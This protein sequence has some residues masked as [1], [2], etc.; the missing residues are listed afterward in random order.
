MNVVAQGVANGGFW[1]MSEMGIEEQFQTIL[2]DFGMRDEKRN[3]EI[4]ERST[5]LRRCFRTG[6]TWEAP[7][8]QT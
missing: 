3:A 1:G 4:P 8:L 2:P 5:V 6:T 7:K